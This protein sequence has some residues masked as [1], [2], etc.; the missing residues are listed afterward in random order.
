M[1]N[2]NAR[3]IIDATL[4]ARGFKRSDASLT[5][6]SGTLSPNGYKVL[7]EL[8]VPDV[9]FVKLPTITVI[10]KDELPARVIAHIEGDQKLCFAD[11]Q[12][13]RL[14][15]F[16]PGGS[17]LRILKQ[18][19]ATLNR[20][21]GG[22]NISEIQ[23]EYPAYW[24]GGNSE[25]IVMPHNLMGVE[26]G[27]VEFIEQFKNPSLIPIT[28]KG[29]YKTSGPS[30]RCKVFQTQKSLG[31]AEN[32]VKP[33]NLVELKFWLKKN[34][35]DL[36]SN[37]QLQKLCFEEEI[38]VIDASNGWYGFEIKLPQNLQ[39]LRRKNSLRKGFYLK[40]WA[41]K[42]EDFEIQRYRITDATLESIV[43]RSLP[44]GVNPLIGKRI[45]LVGAGTIGS[46]L[47]ELL[48]RA[49]AGCSGTLSI[50]DP[51]YVSVGNLG[52]HTLSISDLWEY[53]CLLYT[54]PSPRD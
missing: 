52:R 39:N 45:L 18:A 13:L 44:N 19:T 22:R 54:S 46:N 16:N 2:S 29:N 30:I 43:K 5:K 4:K 35:G 12:L 36:I 26:N 17:I 31:P 49:G 20:S 14:D 23:Q 9:S 27:V 11:D 50:C 6:Y 41:S 10:N 7:I 42:P 51:D 40:F 24:A 53:N 32:I 8:F 37:K 21:L 48:V 33:K 25:H 15:R 47:A 28:M 34:V 1:K 3:W 38:C